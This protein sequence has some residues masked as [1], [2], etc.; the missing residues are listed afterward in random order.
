M[1]NI[2][3]DLRYA[4]RMLRKNPGF[5]LVVVITLALGIGANTAIFT[6]LDQLLLRTLP[7][8]D[9]QQLVQFRFSGSDS[10]RADSY[11][12]DP[13]TYFSYP[14]Y[15]DMQARNSVF[16]DVL[17]TDST[18]VGLQWHNQ[19]DLVATE[20]VSGNYF[21]MLG[22]RP[23]LG[24]LFV[25]SDDVTQAANPVIVLSY[26]YWQRRF[27]SNPNV[28]DQTVLVNGHPFTVIG[29]AQ[30]GFRSIVVGNA[31]GIFAPMM[32]K[33]QITPTWND[34]DN[35]RSRWLNI[36]GR[37][38]PGISREQAEAETNILWRAI[39][40]DE[41][42]AIPRPSPRFR[43]RF[44][45]KSQVTLLD[46]A[47]GFSPLRDTIRTP[48]LIVMGMVGLVMLMACVNVA[49]LLLVRAAGR[50]KEISVRY[51]LGAKQGRMV[52]QLLVEGVLLGLGGGIFGLLLAGP[53]S[54]ILLLRV[55]SDSSGNIPF[56]V[57]PDS[58][59]LIFNFGL[60][61]L[62]SLLFSLAPAVHFWS[63]DLTPALKQQ[64]TTVGGGTL[65]FRRIAA[66]VQIGL[67]LLLLVG[68]GLFVRTL[69]NLRNLDAGLVTDHLVTFGIE[70]HLAGYGEAQVLPLYQRM[71]ATIGGLP[72]VRA[73]AATNDPVLSNNVE[74]SSVTVAG[75]TP[76]EDED[77]TVEWSTVTPTYLYTLQTPLLAGRDLSESD[78][79]GL[80]ES[81]GG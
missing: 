42:K 32:M 38:K 23:A 62:V 4:F 41:L 3:Q 64:T 57:Q 43:E 21:Q 45:E 49:G 34:L 17:S 1:E 14:M 80:C 31:P 68:S 46:G 61:I 30:S 29:V 76:K 24:R 54:R 18:Q 67:S 19:P 16:S 39:R 15:R 26:A 25:P 11:G 27:G 75:Y 36:F 13:G 12:G 33:P 77:M 70:P 65:R 6:V 66:G 53:V 58:R 78:G 69:Y 8:R 10:G 20:L 51:A 5:T 79:P 52:Q 50:A 60:A 73:I 35:R 48:L 55:A 71:L 56:S 63:P 7:V 40:S 59:I 44:V 37:L 2:L 28:L 74:N 81:R 47:R 22:V 72:G 9:P